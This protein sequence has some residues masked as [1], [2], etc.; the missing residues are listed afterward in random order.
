MLV[1][2]VEYVAAGSTWVSPAMVVRLAEG[3]N[4]PVTALSPGELELGENPP[5][6]SWDLV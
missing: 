5:D 2:A 4:T 3:T 6:S 1:Q